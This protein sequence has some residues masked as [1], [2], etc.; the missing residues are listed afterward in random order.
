M[1]LLPREVVRCQDRDA[2]HVQ[3]IATGLWRWT[4][5]HPAWTP[6]DSGP[7]GWEQEVSSYSYEGPD[8]IV[9]VDPLVPAEDRDRFFEALDR[10]VARAGLPVRVLITYDGHRRSADELVERYGATDDE[11]AGGV[12]IAAESLGERVF[13]IP[14]HGAIVVGDTFL[15]RDGG[16]WLPRPWL[17]DRYDEA[18]RELRPLLDLPVERVLTTHGE[19]V[20][21]HGR[22]ALA[23]ALGGDG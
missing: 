3:E 13:W 20:L 9:L 10:D 17:G 12:E 21:E 6:A 23:A 22:E 11:Q 15:G 19:P 5:L 2:V 1:E 4:G 7:E 16:L 8:A 18:V 14:A